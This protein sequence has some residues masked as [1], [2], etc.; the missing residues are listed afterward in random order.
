MS[1]FLCLT[2]ERSEKMKQILDYKKEQ[3]FNFFVLDYEETQEPMV[4][5][6]PDN[7]MLLV[8]KLASQADNDQMQTDDRAVED[9]FQDYLMQHRIIYH[10][11]GYINERQKNLYFS[12]DINRYVVQKERG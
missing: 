3:I 8:A 11:I 7:E 10:V 1:V 2:Y 5:L 4:F 12:D 6:V 9:L